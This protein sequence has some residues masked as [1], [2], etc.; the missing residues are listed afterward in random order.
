MKE[1]ENKD[2]S[3]DVLHWDCLFESPEKFQEFMRQF[4][5]A[6]NK[7]SGNNPQEIKKSDIVNLGEKMTFVPIAKAKPELLENKENEV[8]VNMIKKEDEIEKFYFLF[9]DGKQVSDLVFRK[10]KYKTKFDCGFAE[11]IAYKDF[12]YKN[13]GS[14]PTLCIIND[15]GE[16]VLGKDGLGYPYHMKGVIASIGKKIYNLKTKEV[17]VA[18]NAT[19]SSENYL[20]VEKKYDFKW[21]GGKEKEKGVY[22]ICFKTGEV[23]HFK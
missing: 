18:G 17:I 11:V 10:A 12:F 16:I 19:I 9:K 21:Y 2:N 22:Q 3:R 15:N 1:K 6:L 20:F 5:F 7:V 23:K 8:F 4:N 13:P 14:I